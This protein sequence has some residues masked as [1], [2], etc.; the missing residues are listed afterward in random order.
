MI[1]LFRYITLIVDNALS[2][3][4]GSGQ[5]EKAFVERGFVKKFDTID[6]THDNH[7]NGV[8][9][10]NFIHLPSNKYDFILCKSILH[11]IINL[12]HLFFQ[13]NKALTNDGI[14]VVKEFCGESK[15]QWSNK[16]IKILNRKIK[17]KFGQK[18]PFLKIAK[19]P[20]WNS[21]PFE[22][23][24]S[25]EIHPIIKEYFGN[26]VYKT[27]IHRNVRLGEAPSHGQPI[28]LYDA[29]SIGAQDYMNLTLEVLKK[30]E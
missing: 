4:S 6:I 21:C 20:M 15:S 16:K 11:H 22:G 23:I 18:Y 1:T 17:N 8:N 30:N 27:T 12:E 9:D 24:R 2:L 14:L 5:I 25:S 7:L 19:S 28:L 3:G 26:K 13:V 10:L 29:S